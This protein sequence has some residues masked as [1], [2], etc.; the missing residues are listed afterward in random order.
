MKKLW[1]TVCVA[2][3][4]VMLTA[5]AS[6]AVRYTTTKRDAR[7]DVKIVHSGFAGNQDIDIRWAH[8]QYYGYQSRYD[9][10]VELRLR[11]VRPGLGTAQLYTTEFIKGGSRYRIY[12]ND[13]GGGS[14]Y[15]KSQG[16]WT[17]MENCDVHTSLNPSSTL[18]GGN[19][20]VI[21]RKCWPEKRLKILWTKTQNYYSSSMNDLAA[22]DRVVVKKR[23]GRP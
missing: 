9:L 11:R 18:R 17:R 7:K 8:Y 21:A 14:L 2:M 5:S 13:T 1:I 23:I 10:I 12:G 3:S 19:V 22:W 15:L 20:M 6:Y 16:V 4:I